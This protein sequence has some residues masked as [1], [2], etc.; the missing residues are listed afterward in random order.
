[1]GERAAER[2]DLAFDI[3]LEEQPLDPPRI[4]LEQ[5]RDRREPANPQQLPSMRQPVLTFVHLAIPKWT[6]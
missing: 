5:S 2:P 3:G 6:N 1:M 4:A